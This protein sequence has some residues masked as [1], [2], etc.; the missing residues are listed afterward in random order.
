VHVCDAV[1]TGDLLYIEV[2]ILEGRTVFITAST[3][4]FFVNQVR[5]FPVGYGRL[6]L[7]FCVVFAVDLGSL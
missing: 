3:K 7:T 4:G 2:S 5:C 1:E 6:L